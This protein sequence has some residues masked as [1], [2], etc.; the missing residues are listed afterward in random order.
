ML[1]SSPNKL[2]L[3]KKVPIGYDSLVITPFRSRKEQVKLPILKLN[4]RSP[5]RIPKEFQF[6]NEPKSF[7]VSKTPF[8]YKKLVNCS[9]SKEFLINAINKVQHVMLV[10]NLTERASKVN[11]TENCLSGEYNIKVHKVDKGGRVSCRNTSQA[12]EE[13]LKDYW[14]RSG[15]KGRSNKEGFE[16]NSIF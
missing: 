1:K 14:L 4:N 7:P 2:K 6:F 11:D 8:P 16:L 12:T 15:N 5:R 3:P 10:K 9:I 13:I